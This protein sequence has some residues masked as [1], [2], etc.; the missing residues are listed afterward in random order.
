MDTDALRN[1]AA[2]LAL[3]LA[4]TSASLASEGDQVRLDSGIVQ[5][6]GADASGIRAFKGIPFAA[7]P[8]GELRWREPQPVAP[9]PGVR[10]ATAF[11]P[12]PMQRHIYS[13][14]VFRDK[15]PSEDCLY[16]NVWTPARAPSDRLPVMVWIYGGGFEAG[17]ASE[18]RQDGRLLARR[19]VVVVSLNYRLGIFGFFSHP[20]LSAESGHGSGNY[21]ILDQVAALRWVQRNIAAFGGDPSNVTIFGE[22]AGSYSVSLIMATPL[23]RGLFQ[24]AIWESGSMVGTTRMPTERNTRVFDLKDAES[25][26]ARLARSLGAGSLAALRALPADKV[27]SASRSPLYKEEGRDPPVV[28]DGYLLPAPPRTVFLS[29][30]QAHVP[31]LAGWTADENRAYAVLGTQRPT[32]ASYAASVRSRYPAYADEILR[33]YPAATDAEAVKSAGDLACDGFIV[34]SVRSGLWKHLETGGAPVYAYQ[35]DRAVPIPEGT[36]INGAKVTSAETGARHASEIA[37]VF[38]TFDSEPSVKWQPGDERLSDAIQQY[39]TNFAKTGSPN[40]SDLPEWPRYLGEGGY[41]V[42]HLDLSPAPAPEA[43]RERYAFW[44]SAP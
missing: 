21:G 16:L 25:Q 24:K 39:W 12:R 4:M 18:P 7:P 9:W 32:A 2:T 11:G 41:P 37:Y 8:V 31:L 20:A 35:F 42:M 40:G 23:S 15:G 19:G 26:G 30:A 13:D 22:S 29:G 43:H 36:V 3:V 14:M 38:G 44:D 5:G 28:V 10:P 6:T 34:A 27:L 17:A 1:A 33:L